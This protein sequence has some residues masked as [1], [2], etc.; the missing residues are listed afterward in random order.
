MKTFLNPFR[1]NRGAALIIVILIVS[2][3]IPVAL[4]LNRSTRVDIYDAANLS[5]G[6]RLTYVAKSGFHGA[7]ALVGNARGDYDTL[8]EPWANAEAL[9]AQSASLFSDA[10]FVVRVSDEHGKIPLNKLVTGNTVNA[11]IREMLVR[12]LG[13]PGFDLNPKQAGE[14]VD[15]II[16]WMD[17]D[18][19]VTGAGAE[20]A[21]YAAQAFPYA[22][23]NGPLDCIEELLMIKGMTGE[24][25]APTEERPGLADLLTLHGTGALNINTAPKMVLMALSDGITQEAAEKMDLYRRADGN[26]LSGTDWYKKISGLGNI[27][28]KAEMIENQKS[29]AFRIVS[30]G[31]AGQMERTVTG[32]IQRSPFRI[33]TWRIDG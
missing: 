8:R 16:D 33:L 31:M 27:E 25:F 28:I 2:V 13:L 10:R 11:D 14:I 5:D 3:L 4:E 12:L 22:A 15:A 19:E 26:D 6:I 17:E 30:T 23:K 9:S 1:N 7:A 24:I 20:S 21:Y 18:E 29:N 32:V